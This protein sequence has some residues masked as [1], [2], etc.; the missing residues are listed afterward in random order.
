M[1]QLQGFKMIEQNKWT[2]VRTRIWTWLATLQND[3]VISTM[4][5]GTIILLFP[6]LLLYSLLNYTNIR[7]ASVR[8]SI[9]LH[10]YFG[11]LRYLGACDKILT[12]YDCRIAVVCMRRDG[13]EP[14]RRIHWRWNTVRSEIFNNDELKHGIR[15]GWGQKVILT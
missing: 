9:A 12:N 15:Y 3:Q 4:K 6:S 11:R 7:C 2:T 1:P 8:Q 5:L 10:I 13:I 14:F